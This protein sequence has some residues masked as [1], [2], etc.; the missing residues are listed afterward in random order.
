M[1]KR[2]NSSS[3]P[4]PPT[5]I[6]EANPHNNT[7]NIDENQQPELIHVIHQKIT[8]SIDTSGF[9]LIAGDEVLEILYE[10]GKIE[11]KSKHEPSPIARHYEIWGVVGFIKLLSGSY[12]IVITRA[13]TLGQI[14]GKD[15][16]MVKGTAIL[17][18]QFERA[19]LIME[20]QINDFQLFK[21]TEEIIESSNI[22]LP[23]SDDVTSRHVQF[24]SEDGD[25]EMITEADAS[26]ISKTPPSSVS[27]PNR[28]LS[29]PIPTG[30]K[31][32]GA[33]FNKMKTALGEIGKKRT[34]PSPTF[35]SDPEEI[36]ERE[37]EMEISSVN[38][39]EVMSPVSIEGNNNLG[40]PSNSSVALGITKRLSVVWDELKTEVAA[41]TREFTNTQL[42]PIIE[43]E[44]G[45]EGRII[46]EIALLFRSN[47]FFFSYE[48]DLTTS[49]Q[50][51]EDSRKDSQNKPLWQQVDRRF[52]WNEHLSESLIKQELHSW[53]LPIM[54]GYVQI[55]RCEIDNQSFDFIL[56]SRRSRE[57]AGLRYQR[58]GL[59]ESGKVANFVET[60]QIIS[61]PIGDITHVVSFLQIRGS[62]PLFWSQT[63]T[64]LRPKPVLERTEAENKEAFQKHFE[65]LS[66][67]YGSIVSINLA[68]LSGPELVVGSAYRE[69]IVNLAF[70]NVQYVEFDFH[71][72]CKGMKYENISKL[73][74][75]LDSNFNSI[76]YFWRDGDEHVHLKQKG[77]FRTVRYDEVKSL[78]L[79][80][81]NLLFL[82][83]N[84]IDCLDRTN[85]VQSALGRQVLTLQLL[86]LGIADFLDNGISHY[87]NFENIFNNVWANN[88]DSI[89]REYAGT[90]ALKGDFTS[91]MR[92][93]HF[94]IIEGKRNL[95]G[96]VNDASNSLARMY[97]NT[98]KDFLRQATI[99]YILGN[100]DVDVFLELQQKF[101]VSEPGDADRWAK[102][103]AA[104]VETTSEIVIVDNET[105]LNGWTFLS[106][107][108]S[109]TKR[110]KAYEEKVVLLTN[111]A[112]YICTFHYRLDKV[113]QFKRI[114][115]GDITSLEKGEYIL[116]TLHPSCTSPEDNYGFIVYY[117]AVGE[118]GRVNSGSLR[119]SD[120]AVAAKDTKNDKDEAAGIRFTAFK[121]F[122]S[123]LAGEATKFYAGAGSDLIKGANEVTSKQVVNEVIE[124][125]VNACRDIGNSDN[126][127]VLEKPIISLAEATKNTGIMT[128]VGFKVKQALWL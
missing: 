100:R 13:Q 106:P 21:E 41:G 117:R 44:K 64:G 114:G 8:I 12:L 68:E 74:C 110:G 11:K 118:S 29:I 121:A 79:A 73:V 46:K 16:F 86:R 90:S 35:V 109:N 27:P 54:Q 80:I 115:L 22:S 43:K 61:M 97:Q 70:D 45:L 122:R 1:F 32:V 83:Q 112:L 66:E 59:N 65:Y 103:R 105:K 36:A 51:K 93:H 62:I 96:L 128:R 120:V 15:V 17:P 127:I 125:I 37:D 58:R 24:G 14:Q 4:P 119:N 67:N 9:T 53:I 78:K 52:W 81:D 55:E 3:P 60:E 101:E 30:K 34:S 107:V 19:C 113:M 10:T 89:S 116:S 76:G 104:A 71:K 72:E 23:E 7:N 48:F 18:F 50:R 124:N 33:L 39:D 42:P 63:G 25:N 47:S 77:I 57:R 26:Q 92:N 94:F 56:I 28:F 95:Q 20:E 108:E 87:E 5:E 91:L 99:D 38:S 49:L 88:G 102:V 75:S 98:F 123:N 111:K 69:A 84:C 31:P 82:F 85:V 40:N 6:K 126:L 2:K